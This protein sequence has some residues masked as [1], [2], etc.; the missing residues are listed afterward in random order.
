VDS[1]HLFFFIWDIL[2]LVS[3]FLVLY[4]S[5]WK[6]LSGGLKTIL[7]NRWGDFFL[8]FFICYEYLFLNT[9][10]NSYFNLFLILSAFTKSAQFPFIG[11]LIEAMV[12]PTPV[13]SLVHRRTLV[14]SGCFLIFIFLN[15]YDFEF[16]FY[17]FLGGVFRIFL[18]SFLG[19]L[20]KD[21]K[22]LIAWRTLSQVGL[23]YCI[24]GIGSYFISFLYLLSHAFF[25]SLIFLLVGLKIFLEKGNQDFRFNKSYF[26][27]DSFINLMLG[28]G[29]LMSF[30]FSRGMCLKDLILEVF[31]END[32]IFFFLLIYL[33]V[34]VL[35]NFYSL[36]ILIF[37]YE[38]FISVKISSFYQRKISIFVLSLLR[39]SLV[40]FVL[41][42]YLLGKLTFFSG[43]FFYFFLFFIF[44]YF[45]F[46][47]I[48]FYTKRKFLGDFLFKNFIR[49]L[50]ILSFGDL[51]LFILELRTLK[52]Y[53]F[54][55]KG[56]IIQLFKTLFLVMLFFLMI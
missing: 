49:F 14:V 5:N 30:F 33:I 8:L 52:F 53:Y 21:V 15:F 27:L 40:Y 43:I 17:I 38:N 20:E 16:N 44:F 10:I 46:N 31:F 29:S 45:F 48:F 9:I 26:F 4:Y 12:A 6:S 34:L 35:T 19:L 18:A 55:I 22:K 24:F 54:V 39:Y 41:Q 56:K 13:S 11:W 3:F 32:L 25:K 36:K 2:G 47:I 1:F 51:I 28:L 7:R 23:I 37:F 42:N 50:V